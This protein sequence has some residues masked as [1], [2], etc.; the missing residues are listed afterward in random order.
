MIPKDKQF[1]ADE[2][3]MFDQIDEIVRQVNR[4]MDGVELAPRTSA[5]EMSIARQAF[6][7]WQ[8]AMRWAVGSKELSTAS[9]RSTVDAV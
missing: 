4:L 6:R 2:N 3:A 5:R 7:D 1:T 8:D 9:I